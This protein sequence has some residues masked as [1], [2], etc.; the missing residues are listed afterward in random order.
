M[1][2][3]PLSAADN[4]CK[5]RQDSNH[6]RLCND[7]LGPLLDVMSGIEVLCEGWGCV[8][9]SEDHAG[10]RILAG[11]LLVALLGLQEAIPLACMCIQIPIVSL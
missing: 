8:Y 4:A 9:L 7:K 3:F 6:G 11:A 2:Y 10:E 1:Q 5:F